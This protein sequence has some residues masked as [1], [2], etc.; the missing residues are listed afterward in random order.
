LSRSLEDLHPKVR[1]QAEKWLAATKK[2]GLDILVTCTYRSP[3]EQQELY[4][5]GRTKPGKIVT[6]AQP[7]QSLH[8]HRLALDFVP[9]RNGKP[10]WGTQGTDLELWTK[11][12]ELAEAFGFEWAGRWKRFRE[13]PHIQ[14]KDPEGIK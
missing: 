10:V 11:A 7:G 2:A 1:E 8:Q 9:L 5:I 3:E 4:D 13:F 14:I 6:N 12:G